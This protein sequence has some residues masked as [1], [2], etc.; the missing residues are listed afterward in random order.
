[1]M[2][3]HGWPSSFLEFLDLYEPLSEP[4]AGQPAFHVVT[5]SIPGYGFSTTRRGITPAR[6]AAMFVTLMDRL[7]Y[8]RFMVQG[9]DW[10]CLIGTEIARQFP[11]RAIGLHLNC[12]NGSAP[13]D[14]DK[15]PLTAEEQ[16]W[17]ADHGSFVNSPHFS[18][19]SQKPAG[20][21]HGLQDSPVG[22]AAWIGEKLHDWCDNRRGQALSFDR[23]LQ[24]IALYWFTG[25]IAS[26]ILLYYEAAH[27]WPQERFVTVPTAGAIFPAE[28][29][30]IP[31]AWAERV[32][33][34]VQWNVFDRGGH[35][36]PA[37]VPDLIAE[38]LRRFATL[39]TSK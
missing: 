9:G 27:D 16:S 4:P 17:V 18:V 36:A 30:K 37:E 19:Q 14:R 29:V 24:T 34:I 12:V 35:F 10:G 15:I 31:R 21:A 5:P 11:D 3:I 2:L 23:M 26:S 39:L 38:D 28:I 33:N 22:L 1:V 7:G 8:E 25:T 6:I 13:P 20:L 32:Y